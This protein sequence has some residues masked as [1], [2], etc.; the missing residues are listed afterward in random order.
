MELDEIPTNT[1]YQYLN[2]DEEAISA[3][4]ESKE[5]SHVTSLTPLVP[6]LYDHS[7]NDERKVAVFPFKVL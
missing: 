4:V 3:Y 6:S 2:L 1:S 7:E 5:D